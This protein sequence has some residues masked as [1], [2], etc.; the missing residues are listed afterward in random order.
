MKTVA[1]VVDPWSELSKPAPLFVDQ[2][3][4]VRASR[5]QAWLQRVIDWP[6]THKLIRRRA[7]VRL[8]DL[9]RSERLL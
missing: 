3:R 6:K 2:M 9:E 5:D 8:D 4:V 1:Q 7:R